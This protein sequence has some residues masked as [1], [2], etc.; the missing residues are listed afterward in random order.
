M[1]TDA[2]DRN[3]GDR[4]DGSQLVGWVGLIGALGDIK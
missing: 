4:K 2:L 3:L 1:G